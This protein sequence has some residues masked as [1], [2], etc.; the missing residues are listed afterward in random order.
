MGILFAILAAVFAAL[1]VVL[2]KAGLKDIDPVLAFAIQAVLILVITWGITLY[3]GHAN[4]LNNLS[5]RTWIYM[6]A[7]G[8]FTT[9]S[10]VFSYR[11]M[12]LADVSLVNP[13]ERMSL[14]ISVILAAVFLK[15]KMS[16]QAITGVALMTA[17]VL[18]IG[19]AKK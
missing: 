12:K 7:A 17:G 1:V 13:I 14:V 6:L 3:E 18:L 5:R 16:W 11:A 10:T 9:L 8:V 2:T 19:I 15:E 4:Q